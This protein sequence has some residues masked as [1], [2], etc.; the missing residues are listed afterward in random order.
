VTER[1]DE[2]D[3]IFAAVVIACG[4]FFVSIVGAYLIK[5]I[6][7]R[8]E[9]DVGM[10]G[11]KSAGMVIGIAERIIVLTLVL[12]NHFTAITIIF[13]A[14]SIARFNELKNR[15]MS[16]YYFDWFSCKHIFCVDCWCDYTANFHEGLK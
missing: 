5:F 10:S 1:G 15:K 4:Y 3:Y 7:K 9:K 13:A 14:K 2:M 12:V 11:L 6:L 8:Y 16:E